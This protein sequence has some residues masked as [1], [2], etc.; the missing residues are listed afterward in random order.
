[1]TCP[2]CTKAQASAVWCG[3]DSHCH[4]CQ[5]RALASGLDFFH[6]R[7][8]GGITPGYRAALRTLFGDG[9][10]QGHEQVKAE[11]RRISELQAINKTIEGAYS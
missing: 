11:Y 10:K 3:Y 2:D 7:T 5:V 1:M 9:A 8:G 4:G 6:S